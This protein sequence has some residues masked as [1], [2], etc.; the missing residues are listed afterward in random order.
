M[1]IRDEGGSG[2]LLLSEE[3]EAMANRSPGLP[4]Y[5]DVVGENSEQE[6]NVGLH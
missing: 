4:R 3:S 2:M 6:R 5:K 1:E